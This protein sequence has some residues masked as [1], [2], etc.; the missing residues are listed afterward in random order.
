MKPKVAVII[1]V[2][3]VI[4]MVAMVLFSQSAGN[5]YHF[6]GSRI[7]PPIAAPDFTLTQANGE[8]FQLSE[9]RGKVV[10]IFFGYTFCPDVCPTTLAE[11][12]VMHEE[13]GEA[14]EQV[15]FVYITVDPERDTPEVIDRYARAFNPEFIGLSG[16]E[17]ELQPIYDRYGVF[18]EIQEAQASGSY[19]VAHTSVIYVIDKEGNWRL[20]FP[21]E[22]GPYEM[23]EDVLFLVN[24]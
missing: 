7:D 15:E 3:F 16:E 23:A 17:S 21:F 9:Q 6:Q 20:T 12:K 11:Y 14:A 13:L 10:L 24:E 5:E 8:E 22:M 2:V 19:L 1:A 4:A 18:R